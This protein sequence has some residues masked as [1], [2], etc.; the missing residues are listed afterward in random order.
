MAMGNTLKERFLARKA[1]AGDIA[2]ATAELSALWFESGRA[3]EVVHKLARAVPVSENVTAEKVQAEVG[4]LATV[5]ESR[6]PQAG[7]T[8]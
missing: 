1:F 4:E 2:A 3:I 7:K 8:K 5:L 6:K